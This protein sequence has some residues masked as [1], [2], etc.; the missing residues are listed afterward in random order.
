[1]VI[2]AVSGWGGA[3]L[4]W[5]EVVLRWWFGW[6]VVWVGGGG[7]LVY[8]GFKVV[9]GIGRANAGEGYAYDGPTDDMVVKR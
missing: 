2:E 9:R 7:W 1:M 3:G 6:F 5:A 8:G 4:G